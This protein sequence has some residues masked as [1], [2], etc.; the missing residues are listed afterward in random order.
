M[1][2]LD[3]KPKC[4]GGVSF[5]LLKNKKAFTLV[6]MM[7]VVVI[8]SILATIWFLRL[9]NYS[10]EANVAKRASDK[11]NIEQ[12]LEIYKSKEW[13][14]PEF[15]EENGEKIFWTWTWEKVKNR[16][17]VMPVDPIT[18]K[19]Y[20]IAFL[21]SWKYGK[22]AM[23]DLDGEIARANPENTKNILPETEATN[24]LDLTALI[25]IQDKV[26][27]KL[28]ELVR[29]DKTG[30]ENNFVQSVNGKVQES[31]ALVGKV[32][33]M[34]TEKDFEETKVNS[35]R[36]EINN[37]KIEL[38]DLLK[39]IE[40][41][42]N[43][44]K[45]DAELTAK[46][47]E[48][49]VDDLIVLQRTLWERQR[50]LS[51]LDSWN[52]LIVKAGNETNKSNNLVQKILNRN[53]KPDLTLAEANNLLSEKAA[54]KTNLEWVIRE[55]EAEINRINTQRQ[56]ALENA[57][58]AAREEIERIAREEI[59]KVNASG[60]NQSE[61]TNLI[62]RINTAKR[63]AEWNIDRASSESS[64]TQAKN[65]WA[66]EIRK[67]YRDHNAAKERERQQALENAKTA[68]REEIERIAREEIGKVNASG[69]NQSEKTNLI[70][71]INTAKRT[72]EWN[73]DRASSESSVTQAK[74]TWAEEIRKIYRDHNAAKERERQQALENAKNAAREEIER[75]AREEIGKVNTSGLSQSEKTNLIDRINTAKTTAEWNI[76]RANSESNVTQAKNTWVG[77]IRLVYNL[78]LDSV[79]H[80]AVDEIKSF[81]MYIITWMEYDHLPASFRNRVQQVWKTAEA[82]I[83]NANTIEKVTELKNAWFAEIRRIEKSELALAE[84][85]SEKTK[86]R[87]RISALEKVNK[88]GKT[89]ESVNAFNTKVNSAKT[90]LNKAWVTKQ[91]ITNKINELVN[92]EKT[93]VNAKSPFSPNGIYIGEPE[94]DTCVKNIP[95]RFVVTGDVIKDT[96]TG[97]LWSK[98]IA[99]RISWQR[100][101]DYCAKLT[102]WWKTNWR[103]PDITELNSI[104]ND[105]CHAPA[106]YL[107]FFNTANWGNWDNYW[108]STTLAS[109]TGKAWVLYFASGDTDW[110]S[111]TDSAYVLCVAK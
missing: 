40:S 101:K 53:S 58:T 87:N 106:T 2:N 35:T 82:D 81:V 65:T 37:K 48:L 111:K 55:L 90:L 77:E 103:L 26:A 29:L 91:E 110:Y 33:K 44:F 17:P 34:I 74:N 42:I 89:P 86:L 88:T 46:R 57:K 6:E 22:I 109:N 72:A 78:K 21:P 92:L 19:P 71:R 47:N 76:N 67:I 95:G 83:I 63:T 79:K 59:G 31:N 41:K 93:L 105:S 39:Q 27:K 5:Y 50:A 16:L 98:D 52:S 36:D 97:L 45:W 108:S 28:E 94:S 107:E 85:E 84:L 70:D 75:I 68:A 51:S 61:K 32:T 96:R 11:K 13:D 7:V 64:V 1:K 56:Q 9:G 49:T 54:M 8:I 62:D 100:A 69:W 60:W 12:V 14:Y 10:S 99:N 3:F 23:V 25:A 30:S 43:K 102:T 104:V 66:E 80:L 4:G 24:Q 38:T 15:E 18:K 73:I 20:K